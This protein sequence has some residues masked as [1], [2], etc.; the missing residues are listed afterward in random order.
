MAQQVEEKKQVVEQ[1]LCHEISR[2]CC[3]KASDKAKNFVATNP[4]YVATKSGDIIC[5][6]KAI[7]YCDKDRK[8]TLSRQSFTLSQQSQIQTLS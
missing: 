3:D 4:D 5:H 8:Q 2:F 1:K 6:N 7:V